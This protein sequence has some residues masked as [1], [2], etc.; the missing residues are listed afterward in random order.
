MRCILKKE[1]VIFLIFRI[2]KFYPV[3]PPHPPFI[4]P[5]TSITKYDWVLGKNKE[6]KNKNWIHPADSLISGHIVYLVKV[7]FNLRTYRLSE[8]KTK[9]CANFK[10]V[11]KSSVK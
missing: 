11:V 10:F 7:Y 9:E 4:C 5:V 3:P 8:S 6:E 2:Y 1:T